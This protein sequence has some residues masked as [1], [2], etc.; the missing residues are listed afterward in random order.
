MAI[1]W[2]CTLCGQC[3]KSYTPFVLPGD[4]RHILSSLHRPMSSCITFYQAADFENGLSADDRRY[5]FETKRGLV[6]MCLSRVLLPGDEAGC[7]FLNGDLCSIH[8]HR[9]LVCRQ[10]PFQ[11][12][13][14]G[15]ARVPFQLMDNPCF[16]V[17]AEDE[18]VDEGPVRLN[19]GVFQEQQDEFMEKVAR[20]NEDPSSKMKDINEFLS[21]I[22]LSWA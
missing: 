4:V 5:L 16:G 8:T 13:E 10:Y 19:Y 18:I 6:V 2:R 11:P 20:W 1:R 9:P 15:N 22:G 12:I 3:C 17:Y 7:V 21:Y 14:P